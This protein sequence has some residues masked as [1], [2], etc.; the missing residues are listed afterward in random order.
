MGQ[1]RRAIGGGNVMRITVIL[2]CGN[3]SRLRHTHHFKNCSIFRNLFS[4]FVYQEYG[5]LLYF[6]AATFS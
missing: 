6:Q 5:K 3:N 4:Q 1:T 2:P